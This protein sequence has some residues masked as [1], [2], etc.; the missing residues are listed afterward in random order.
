VLLEAVQLVGDRIPV[1]VLSLEVKLESATIGIQNK[2]FVDL[3]VAEG[4]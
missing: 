2:K 3:G 4:G 1:E